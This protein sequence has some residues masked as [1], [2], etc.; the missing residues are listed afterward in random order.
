MKIQSTRQTGQTIKNSQPD[1]APKAEP[2]NE[3]TIK[4]VVEEPARL[5]LEI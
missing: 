4:D 2:T 5:V 1:Q 3:L